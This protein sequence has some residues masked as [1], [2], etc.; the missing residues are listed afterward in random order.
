MTRG[1]ETIDGIKMVEGPC[2]RCWGTGDESLHDYSACGPT[3]CTKCQGSGKITRPPTVAER[4]SVLRVEL[5]EAKVVI[6]A[7]DRRIDELRLQVEKLR[8]ALTEMIVVAET[9]NAAR[10]DQFTQEWRDALTRA[11]S[12]AIAALK[13]GAR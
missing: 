3:S 11:R 12:L 10:G 6:E 2:D 9:A 7:Q 5:D 1:Y 4:L 13:G 8:E